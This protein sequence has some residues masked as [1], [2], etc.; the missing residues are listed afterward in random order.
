MKYSCL[1]WLFK[2]LGFLFVILTC[3]GSVYGSDIN[4]LPT[5]EIDKNSHQKEVGIKT[6]S[7]F[8]AYGAGLSYSFITYF[9][10]RNESN[11]ALEQTVVSQGVDLSAIS[12]VHEYIGFE[13]GVYVGYASKLTVGGS[14]ERQTVYD[15]SQVTEMKDVSISGVRGFL[16]F[17]RKITSPGFRINGGLGAYVEQVII[18]RVKNYTLNEFNSGLALKFSIGYGWER[19]GT[20]FWVNVRTGSAT[21]FENG[22]TQGGWMLSY[23]VN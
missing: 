10:D 4:V 23:R 19:F 6:K 12:R 3:S 9:Y 16:L 21:G 18:K 20:E 2:F 5:G 13:T 22:S 17:G 7:P 1:H 14:E 15:L 8:S 11:P